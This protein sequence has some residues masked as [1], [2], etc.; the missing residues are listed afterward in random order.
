MSTAFIDAMMTDFNLVGD[1]FNDPERTLSSFD[2]TAQ[3]RSAFAA[4]DI[5]ALTSLGIDRGLVSAAL[6]GAHSQTCPK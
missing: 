2:L 6:S 4:R 3:E 5:D 1:Y